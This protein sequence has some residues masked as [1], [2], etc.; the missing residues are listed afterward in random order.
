M[1]DETI[2]NFETAGEDKDGHQCYRLKQVKTGAYLEDPDLSKGVV[3]MTQSVARAFVFTALPGV[4]VVS[5]ED[6][7]GDGKKETT[8]AWKEAD[9]RTKYEP[10]D[11]SFE[12]VFVLCNKH[13]DSQYLLFEI[14]GGNYSCMWSQYTNS[15]VWHIYTAEKVGAYEDLNYFLADNFPNGTA[16]NLFTIGTAPGQVPESFVKALVNAYNSAKALADEPKGD[17]DKVYTEAKEAVSKALKACKENIVQV[18]AGYYIVNNDPTGD[19]PGY[20]NATNATMIETNGQL[21]Y[22]GYEMPEKFTVED[23][24]CIWEVIPAEGEDG[25]WY[26]RNYGT[27]RYAGSMKNTNTV[28]PSTETPQQVFDI[29]QVRNDLFAMNMRGQNADY[30]ALH[31]DKNPGLRIVLWTTAANAS[32]WKFVPVDPSDLKSIDD[33]LEQQ[34]INKEAKNL[35]NNVKIAYAKGISHTSAAT[36]DGLYQEDNMGLVTAAEQYFSYTPEST[37]GRLEDN[38]LLD[39]NQKTIFHSCW[40][41]NDY[42]NVT[43]NICADLTK[44]YAAIAIKYSRRNAGN[45]GVP[46]VMH[47][48]ASNDTTG[49][50]WKE[51][52]YMNLTYKYKSNETYSTEN[53]IADFTGI[54]SISFDAPYRFVRFDVEKTRTN[55]TAQSGIYFNFSELRIYEATYDKSSS[56]IE[57]VPEDIK[58]NLADALAV[59][60]GQLAAG[61]VDKTALETLQNAYDQFTENFPDPQVVKNLLNEAKAQAENAEEQDELGYF[62]VGAKQ[63]LLDVIASVEGQIK[64]VMTIDEIN[65]AKATIEA[66]LADFNSKLN[67]PENGQIFYIK[68]VTESGQEGSATDNYMYS[69]NSDPGQIKYTLSEDF[70]AEIN[71]LW[72]TIKN[73]DGSYSFMNIGTGTYMGNPH[74]NNA[75]VSTS[76]EKDTLTLRSAK[77]GGVFNLVCADNVFYNAQPGTG[78]IVTW[79][80]ANGKDNSAFVFIPWQEAP[81][82]W[83]GESISLNIDNM[84]AKIL[85]YPY[86]LSAY[87]TNCKLYK[88]LGLKDNTLQLAEYDESAVIPAATPFIM[89]PESAENESEEDTFYG[90]ALAK[91]VVSETD[92]IDYVFEN[93]TQNGMIASLQTTKNIAGG[94]I[95]FENNVIEAVE[96]DKSPANSGYFYMMPEE[97]TEDGEMTMSF[98][99]NIETAIENVVLTPKAKVGVYSITG[100]KVRNNADL[101]NLPKGIYIVNGKRLLVK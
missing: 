91:A 54:A 35:V 46:T 4:P 97:T 73:E 76:L 39:N 26:L 71:Y 7:D 44:E 18:T 14:Y 43:H 13:L 77:V 27:N 94:G 62:E 81:D 79:N 93:Q 59:I 74:K 53:S 8:E 19:R 42:A 89:K 72:R 33:Q 92:S 11:Q 29:V 48:Y 56:L 83:D 80:S 10:M 20:A 60:E 45:D 47:V 67:M 16:E 78:N 95:L 23:A 5:T 15:R 9:V 58:K 88:V 100:V 28:V 37:E 6:L 41:S 87:A 17:D 82:S 25:G 86:A 49:G 61:N 66:A 90:L 12:N 99:T 68:S 3:N 96:E 98:P 30:P 55:A 1:V 31:A 85:S 32:I 69:I 70:S 64:D 52:G 51:Q 65:K 57:A 2:Y 24:P 63:G 50:A 34:R 21:H 75:R 36:P 22:K 38:G 40:S 101:N 84:N